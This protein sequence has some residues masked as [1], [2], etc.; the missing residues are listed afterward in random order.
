MRNPIE[1]TDKHELESKGLT[2]ESSFI[3]SDPTK[4]PVLVYRVD[5]TGSRL[6]ALSPVVKFSMREHAI[7][8]P[9]ATCIQLA[10]ARYY[11]EYEESE[12]DKGIRDEQEA[13]YERRTNMKTFL[14]ESKLPAPAG[15]SQVS[16]QLTYE[17]NDFWIFCTSMKPT[18][19][20]ELRKMRQ[21]FGYDCATT[22]ANPSEFAKELGSAFATHSEWSDVVSL[23]PLARVSRLLPRSEV[24]DKSVFVHHGPV[25]YQCNP[26]KV[27]EAFPEDKRGAVA[28]FVKRDQFSHQ[29]EY[30]FTVSIRGEPKEL[31]FSL[32]ISTELRHLAKF[33][34]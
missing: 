9:E 30:R 2:L 6:K 1:I 11:R 17:S 10:T 14:D 13:R 5:L 16:L 15:A 26:A 22:I 27:I 29:K 18:T 8:N 32:P 12:G 23:S 25:V 34:R 3:E 24:G 20:W 4:A 21:A 7:P 33:N 31:T 28:P 19:D